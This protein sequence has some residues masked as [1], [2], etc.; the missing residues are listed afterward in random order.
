MTRLIAL[1]IF[2]ALLGAS[3]ASASAFV[4]HVGPPAAGSGG[5]NPVSIP[6]VS[7]VEY[8]FV[9][10]T[11]KDNEITVGIFPGMFY[12]ARSQIVGGT[13]VGFGG[14]LV[15]STNGTGPGMYSCI[16]TDLGSGSVK[17]NAEYKQAVGFDFSSDTVI[18]PYGV[19]IGVTFEW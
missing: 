11:D 5:P 13:Y 14:G 2:V 12:G 3:R 8:E 4:T 6:P 17:F 9:Y 7:I 18:S 19:R 16:G 10:V 15:L 1:A